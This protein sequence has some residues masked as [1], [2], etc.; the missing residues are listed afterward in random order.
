VLKNSAK[1]ANN[2][3]QVPTSAHTPA[4]RALAKEATDD[5]E[6]LSPGHFSEEKPRPA[7]SYS[8]AEDEGTAMV[9]TNSLLDMRRTTTAF[10]QRAKCDRPE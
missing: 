1:E 7:N 3:E 5:Y 4:A 6:H 8:D 10:S 9:F 2:F